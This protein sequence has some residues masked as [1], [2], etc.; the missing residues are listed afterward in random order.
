MDFNNFSKVLNAKN[1]QQENRVKEDNKNLYYDKI[2]HRACN[3]INYLIK[4]KDNCIFEIPKFL[5]GVPKYDITSCIYYVI[6]KLRE[7]DF[8]AQLLTQNYIY[9]SWVEETIVNEKKKNK[10]FRFRKIIYNLKLK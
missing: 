8:Q 9:I 1:L 7:N 2:Y 3:R 4:N 5:I 10:I 6:Q